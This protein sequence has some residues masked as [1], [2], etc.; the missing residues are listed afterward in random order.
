MRIRKGSEVLLWQFGELNHVA[1][2]SRVSLAIVLIGIVAL[3]GGCAKAKPVHYYQIMYPSSTIAGANSLD[4]SIMVRNLIAS[5]LYRE[6]RIVFGNNAE[7]MGIYQNERWAEAPTDMLQNAL[8][9]G[10][11]ASG[12]FRSVTHLRSDSEGDFILSGHLF[13]FKEMDVNGSQARL[14]FDVEMRDAKTNKLVWTY[15]YNHDEPA[16]GK[17]VAAVASAMSKNVEDSVKK[18]QAG[19]EEYFR[20][21]PPK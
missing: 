4:V 11:R 9:R 8:V 6:D 20:D 15:A 16:N 2:L 5:H 1:F 13:E 21:H 14:T 18:V 12:R 3:G 10:L 19:L 7:E 17:A